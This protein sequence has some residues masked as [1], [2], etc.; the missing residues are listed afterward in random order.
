MALPHPRRATPASARAIDARS[1]RLTAPRPA[2]RSPMAAHRITRRERHRHADRLGPPARP[3]S[4][5]ASRD[6]DRRAAPADRASPLLVLL[7]SLSA[8]AV[9]ALDRAA[10]GGTAGRRRGS[11]RLGASPARR[12]RRHLT[13]GGARRRRRGRSRRGRPASTSPSDET[14]AQPDG[15]VPRR[16]HAAQA[17]RRRHDRRRRRRQAPQL[18]A[19]ATATR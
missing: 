17:R 9:P 10:V 16:R 5:R 1:R 3:S 18:Q 6:R 14:A 19:S 7:A 2:R 13:I 12:R 8:I 4:L 11:P 15:A